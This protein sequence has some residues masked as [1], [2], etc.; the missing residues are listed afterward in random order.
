MILNIHWSLKITISH[1]N[2]IGACAL[3][4]GGHGVL[5]EYALV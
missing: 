5:Y 4:L 1:K 3:I 2:N